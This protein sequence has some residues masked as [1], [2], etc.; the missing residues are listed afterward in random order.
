M[1]LLKLFKVTYWYDYDSKI[2]TFIKFVIA[3][4]IVEAKRIVEE[5]LFTLDSMKIENVEEIAQLLCS[6]DMEWHKIWV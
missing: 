2:G 5:E 6:V 4:N 1:I 3:R